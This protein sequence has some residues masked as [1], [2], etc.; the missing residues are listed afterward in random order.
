MV[1]I[2]QR[3][4]EF[5]WKEIFSIKCLWWYFQFPFFVIHES[6]HFFFNIILGVPIIDVRVNLFTTFQTIIN[7]EVVECLSW[8]NCQI[9]T[10]ADD[11]SI[12]DNVKII[13]AAF[14]P[15]IVYFIILM[16]FGFF[17]FTSFSY[18]FLSGFLYTSLCVNTGMASKPDFE[19][20]KTTFKHLKNNVH[21]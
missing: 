14:S 3:I 10:L 7:E 15:T 13:I 4:S 9:V 5:S 11:E 8:Y 1:N 12:L 6:S 2:Q 20:I 17:C 19:L 18:L 16:V 21:F